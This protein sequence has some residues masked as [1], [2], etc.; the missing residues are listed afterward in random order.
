MGF[1]MNAPQFVLN[2][3]TLREFA[4]IRSDL[5]TPSQR[6]LLETQDACMKKTGAKLPCPQIRESTSQACKD[7]L[8]MKNRAAAGAPHEGMF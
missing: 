2:E 7:C 8:V 1:A 3:D 4:A 5:V 6:D